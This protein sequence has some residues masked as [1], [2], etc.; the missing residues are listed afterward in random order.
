M[1][2]F[3]HVLGIHGDTGWNTLPASS[4]DRIAQW[5]KITAKLCTRLTVWPE[6]RI[7]LLL[8]VVV[9]FPVQRDSD[10]PKASM[11]LYP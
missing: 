10:R 7:I 2:S 1:C 9:P 3:M 6:C 8:L 11:F 5:L 4:H